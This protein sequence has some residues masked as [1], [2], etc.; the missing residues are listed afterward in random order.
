MLSTEQAEG[1]LLLP[2][3]LGIHEAVTVLLDEVKLCLDL[4]IE[5]SVCD[6]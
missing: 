1:V 5:Y 4:P 2:E 6:V 3:M